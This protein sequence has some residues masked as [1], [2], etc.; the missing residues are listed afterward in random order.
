MATTDH[1]P[2]HDEFGAQA[3]DPH[4]AHQDE[5]YG[6]STAQAGRHGRLYDEG[7]THPTAASG[8]HGALFDEFGWKA[9]DAGHGQNFD[10]DF[11]RPAMLDGVEHGTWFDIFRGDRSVEIKYIFDG[12]DYEGTV[13]EVGAGEVTVQSYGQNQGGARHTI[14]LGQMKELRRMTRLGGPDEDRHPTASPGNTP[15]RQRAS[16]AEAPSAH[17]AKAKGGGRTPVDA[18]TAMGTKFANKTIDDV[19]VDL[20]KAADDG[21]VT[22]VHATPEKGHAIPFATHSHGAC[23]TCGTNG[24]RIHFGSGKVCKGCYG[25]APTRFPGDAKKTDGEIVAEL[26]KVAQEL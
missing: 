4:G 10:T 16:T 18:D 20:R 13:L 8:K 24:P 7:Y 15:A 25:K 26:R 11:S 22:V 14:G 21:P 12:R 17:D 1:G 2:L 6:H 5:S 3:T 19:V 23:T 9:V